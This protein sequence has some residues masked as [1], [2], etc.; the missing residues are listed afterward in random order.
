MLPFTVS[1][2]LRHVSGDTYRP[3]VENTLGTSLIDLEPRVCLVS[4]SFPP[5]SKETSKEESSDENVEKYIIIRDGES[6]QTQR[7]KYFKNVHS[8]FLIYVSWFPK[9]CRRFQYIDQW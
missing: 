5:P 3:R 4:G 2:S 7:S 6:K 8:I 9:I 1:N